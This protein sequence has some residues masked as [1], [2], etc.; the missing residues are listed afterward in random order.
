MLSHQ[1]GAALHTKGVQGQV[2]HN[3][4]LPQP[5]AVHPSQQELA[6]LSQRSSL[7]TPLGGL[8]PI[9]PFQTDVLVL[10]PAC[11]FFFFFFLLAAAMQAW[12]HWSSAH[13]LPVVR[14]F[15]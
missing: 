1:Q 5:E 4:N 7:E 15:G 9:R 8:T 3:L 11:F 10:H 12:A 14:P 2:L 6:A 13:L